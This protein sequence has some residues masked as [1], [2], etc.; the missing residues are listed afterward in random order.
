MVKSSHTLTLSCVK[1]K[2][3]EYHFPVL[4]SEDRSRKNAIYYFNGIEVDVGFSNFFEILNFACYNDI[5]FNTLQFK[6]RSFSDYIVLK[7]F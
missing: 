2:L 3:Y 1:E 6:S 5:D 7:Y 4:L